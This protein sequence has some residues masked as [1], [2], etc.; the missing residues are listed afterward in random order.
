MNVEEVWFDGF[1]LSHV[2]K[3]INGRREKLVREVMIPGTFYLLPCAYI[4]DF[5]GNTLKVCVFADASPVDLVFCFSTPWRR[6][7]DAV[8]KQ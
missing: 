6:K 4:L 5:F 3:S 1:F 2:Y 8:K 7:I